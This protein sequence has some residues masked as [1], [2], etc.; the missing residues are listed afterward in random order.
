MTLGCDLMFKMEDVQPILDLVE[1]VAGLHFAPNKLYF[2]EKR[3]LSRMRATNSKSLQDYFRL[4][5][6]SEHV[7]EL[8]ELICALTTN[9]TYFYRN[10]PQLEA[11]VEEALP[12]VIEEKQR[13]GDFTIRIWSAACSSGEE[14]YNIVLLLKEHLPNYRSWNIEI[15]ATDI[16]HHILEKA[17]EGIY[18]KRQIKQVP[19]QILEKYFR[20]RGNQYKVS[21]DLKRQITFTQSNLMDRREVRKFSGMDFVFC[22]NVLIYF[23][24]ESKKQIVNSIYDCLNPGGFIFVGHAESV[25]KISALFKLVKFQKSLAYQK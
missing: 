5:K 19:P 2:T 4:V 10:I 25:G 3:I 17:K 1:E 14:P 23:N 13:K 22:R 18:D 8:Q 16:D 24:E 6:L 11:F 12:Q 15:I 21:R 9:E 7:E 20:P